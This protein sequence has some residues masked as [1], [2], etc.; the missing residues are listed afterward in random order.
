MP[1]PEV[2]DA[3]DPASLARFDDI[4]DVR[5]PGEFAEDHV[6]GAINLP[7]LDN[8]ERAVVGT[9]YVQDS[10]FRARRVGAAL[11][12]RNVAH[13][14]ETV[15]ADRPADYKP[16]VYC[17]RG[18]QRSNA[19]ATIFGQIGW[20]TFVLGGGYRT[21][22]RRVQARLYNDPLN[23]DLILL[24]GGTGT[25]KTEVL[26][27]LARLGVQTLDLEALA[28]HRGS[29]FGG[30]AGEAQPHQKMFESRL[31]QALDGL[32]PTRPVVAEAESHKIGDRM[33]PPGLWQAM[34]RA[35]RIL[36]TAPRPE[37]AQYLVRAYADIVAD[38]EALEAIIA[39]L[40]VHIGRKQL[41]GLYEQAESGAFAALAETLMALHYDPAYDR[42]TRKEGRAS[43]ARIDLERLDAGAMEQAANTVAALLNRRSI[44]APE[45]A[46][47]SARSP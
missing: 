9:I 21:Y 44:V 45:S 39:R 19:M 23:L 34:A 38:P 12:A 18:G 25:G 28:Q 4:I 15:L 3:A 20:R 11:V 13:H 42:S 43:L 7:V 5:S 14:L 2:L 36:L 10:A 22:R 37:R 33:L 40:P 46:L 27:A 1:N 16:L 24:D 41:E 35:P 30:R 47:S 31:L 6:P 32:D 26:H 29:L 17:W 8:A